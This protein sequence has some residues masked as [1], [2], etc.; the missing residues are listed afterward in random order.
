[1]L[2]TIRPLAAPG[3]RA[4]VTV[5]ATED[6]DGEVEAGVAE[7]AD[8]IVVGMGPGGDDLANRLAEAGRDVIGIDAHLVGGE[9]PYYGCIP[10]KMII[11]AA[12][13]LA[14]AGR[15]AQLAGSATVTPDFGPVATRISTEATDNWDDKV[16]VERFTGK[17]GRFV[18]GRARLTGPH[19]VTVEGVD[20]TAP[21][22][23]LNTGTDPL[24]PPIDGLAGTPFWTNRDI[25]RATAAPESLAV[26][27][28]GPIGAEL[29]QAFSRF[30]T[31]VSVITSGALLP[32]DEPEAG[33]LLA[34]VFAAAGITVHG[35]AHATA[36]T[37]DGERFTIT[38]DNGAEPVTAQRLLV[39]TGRRTNLD[40]LGIDV[41]G[42]DPKAKTVSPDERLRIAEGVYAIGD[43]TGKGAF[44]H[45]SMY[46]ARIVFD[47]LMG[48]PGPGAEYHAVP[49]VTFTDPEVGAVGLTEAQAREA[50]LNV[51][52]GQTELPAS[53][54]GW[55]HHVGNEGFIK[56]VEDA[57]SGVLVGA[58]TV[59][60][61]GG[62][63]LAALSVA[64]QAA[65]PTAT[66]ARTIYAFPTFHRALETA[67]ADLS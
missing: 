30:G 15:V 36:V 42:L 41:L 10:S 12:S 24:V 22:I 1:M 37:H 27:G 28:G 21:A 66:L 45:M 61:S 62:E 19:T 55:I 51:R 50:G 29:A 34:E 44:T 59:G 26:L 23:V 11:R 57:D 52:I 2:S 46:Q 5:T 17:G 47:E 38:L 43:I 39:A 8:V 6:R 32:R 67:L 7:S 31:E 49:R 53:S 9:C 3:R 63:M 20:Y 13:A 60:P 40:K 54:R 4:A 48:K 65:V 64:V 16:A 58:T 25:L 35:G 14:E 33:K 56:L 18:R